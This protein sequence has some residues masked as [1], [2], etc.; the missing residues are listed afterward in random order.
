M[1]IEDTET[2]SRLSISTVIIT[3]NEEG[4]IAECLQSVKWADEI[5][6]VD[7]ESTDRTQELARG[8]SSRVFVRP[9]EG[10]GPQK[11]FGILQATGEW[12]LILDADERVSLGLAKEIQ[13]RL[14]TWTSGDPRA[15]CVPRRNV[16]YGEWVRWGGAYPD[17]QIRLFQNGQ[18]TYNDV[19]I[20]E[21]LIVEGCIGEFEGY[22]EHYTEKQIIDHF[23]KFSHYITLAAK[24]K[25]KSTARV[26]W[27]HLL[28]NP[29]GTFLK[30]Y[31]LKQGFR[32]G[33]RGI[34]FAGF[35]SMYTF[36]KYAK[37]FESRYSSDNM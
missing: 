18:A 32:D 25:A 17:L 23:K 22:L 4:N 8:Y 28:L 11:N 15:F 21:N 37:L 34:I 36:G 9:W 27:W 30:K 14:T 12:I 10:Y 2:V 20:H 7:S 33:I 35:A 26:Q 29:L 31:C 24:E 3:K 1:R 6:V 5:I 13:A 16:F 19:E